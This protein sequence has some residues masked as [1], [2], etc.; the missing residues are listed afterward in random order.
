MFDSPMNRPHN[1]CS[2]PFDMGFMAMNPR[3]N[4]YMGVAMATAMPAMPMYPAIP[5]G[6]SLFQYN[7]YPNF[8]TMTYQPLPYQPYTLPSFNMPGNYTPFGYNN[9]EPMPFQL[10]SLNTNNFGALFDLSGLKLPNLQ[11][12]F[13]APNVNLSEI[14]STKTSPVSNES[15]EDI[16]DSNS[17]LKPGLFKGA[18]AGKEALVTKICRK[19][20]VSPQLVASIIGLESGW[21]TSNLAMHNNFGGY[22]AAGDLGKNEKGFGYFSTPEKGLEAMIKN[23]AGYTRYS[24]VSKVD[25]ANLDNIGRHYCEEGVWAERVRKMYNSR[26]KQY[27]A[28]C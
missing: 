22:R 24:D 19:Y 1:F 16:T 15:I 28:V 23:L 25:F 2:N 9:I 8:G 17:D 13:K 12:F 27:S 18:L 20:G 26:V 10:P 6:Y 14:S 11:N 5:M 21:G 4:F 7:C 3:R